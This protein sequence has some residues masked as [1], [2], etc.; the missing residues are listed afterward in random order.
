[1]VE[2]LKVIE[3]AERMHV[4][5]QTI[6]AWI[7]S[8]RIQPVRTAGGTLRIPEDQLIAPVSQRKDVARTD[9]FRVVDIS[10]VEQDSTEPVGTKEKF[11]YWENDGTKFLFKTGR[12]NT[13]D[14]WAE[15][16]ASELCDLL[17]VPHA[18]Y[19]LARWHD[20]RGVIT[21]SF[22]PQDC[23][24]VH[25]NELLAELEAG[26]EKTRRYKQRKHTL[27][28]VLQIIGRNDVDSPIG[29]RGF[30]EVHS[31]IDVFVGYLM[32]DAW[33]ANQDRHHENWAIVETIDG[34]KH[35]APSYD[36]A[37]SL[38]RN[39]VDSNRERRLAT[40]D[41]GYGMRQY[42]QRAKSAFYASPDDTK[43]MSTL[44]AFCEAARERTSAAHSWLR[45]MQGVSLVDTE[46]I[47][48]RL[49]K[50]EITEVEIDFAQTILDLNRQRILK[51]GF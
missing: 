19:D 16:I 36:H 13:G 34:K 26:Y 6:Y 23:R 8:G 2:L 39:E 24:L 41:S 10:H 47:L 35:L 20:I 38:G 50:D 44:D 28:L 5:R 22:V 43:P 9:V 49:P 42:V 18:V 30:D 15:K 37:A 32:L 21:R 51:L 31:A 4:T 3:A 48:K 1:M 40:K 7:K 46:V 11:W 29:W 45:R 14:N 25:G 33:I 12:P 17:G 27:T